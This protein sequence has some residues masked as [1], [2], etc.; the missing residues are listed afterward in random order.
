M[1]SQASSDLAPLHEAQTPQPGLLHRLLRRLSRKR[2]AARVTSP[3]VYD[4]E[5]IEEANRISDAL[6]RQHAR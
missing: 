3:L 5:D 6:C 2:K 4:A 1:H